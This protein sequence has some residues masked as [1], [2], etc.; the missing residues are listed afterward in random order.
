[1]VENLT[2]SE[3]IRRNTNITHVPRHVFYSTLH[4][5]NVK[6]DQCIPYVINSSSSEQ[7]SEQEH[8]TAGLESQ[9]ENLTQTV[10]KLQQKSYTLGRKLTLSEKKRRNLETQLEKIQK[11]N[12]EC[13]MGNA[14]V[15]NSTL[16]NSISALKEE[17]QMLKNNLEN[18][19]SADGSVIDNKTA[20]GLI[21]FLCVLLISTATSC[22]LYLRE[23]MKCKK[24]S[25]FQCHHM[26]RNLQTSSTSL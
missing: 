1:M 8:T 22:V 13:N 16:T 3:I 11:C 9:V 20:V 5:M 23:K 21:V 17:N 25:H 14:T 24:L 12:R 10:Q 6:N 18:L 2:L 19:K 7:V 15:E 26:A 4:C